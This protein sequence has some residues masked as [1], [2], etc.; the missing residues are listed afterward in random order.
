MGQPLDGCFA[1]GKGLASRFSLV[2]HP[3]NLLLHLLQ[4]PT[5]TLH[6]SLQ[7]RF[8]VLDPR[9]Q[10]PYILSLA[11]HLTTTVFAVVDNS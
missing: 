4:G 10:L 5:Q 3:H 9:L 7:L 8:A 11:L 2:L 6:R 1:V